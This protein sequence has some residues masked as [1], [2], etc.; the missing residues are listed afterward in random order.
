MIDVWTLP[1]AER[2][3]IEQRL[4]QLQRNVNSRKEEI[5][6]LQAW[7][8]NLKAMQEDD[9]QK[10]RNLLNTYKIDW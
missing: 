3:G 6:K 5:T 2:K 7:L 10:I 8:N 4:R 1:K 9:V